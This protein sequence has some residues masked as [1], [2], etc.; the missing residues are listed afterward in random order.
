MKA[1]ETIKQIRTVAWSAGP[2]CH[3]GCGQK[4]YVQ[5]GKVIGLEGDENYPWNQGRSCPRVLA[6]TQ[7][8]YHADRVTTP[9]RRSGARGEG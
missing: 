4:L 1:E 3:G 2:G 7:H 9:L 6:M 5:Y 8:M